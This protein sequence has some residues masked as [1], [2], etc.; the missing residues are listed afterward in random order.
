MADRKRNPWLVPIRKVLFR[1]AFAVFILFQFVVF[2]MLLWALSRILPEDNDFIT[3]T[4]IVL[5]LISPF[6]IGA[7]SY[8]VFQRMTRVEYILAESERWLAERRETRMAPHKWRRV[9]RHW[10]VWI[11]TLTVLLFCL[12]LDQTL[13]P[14]SHLLHPG[15][16]RLGAYR[17]SLPLDWTVVF[18]ESGP[19]GSPGRLYAVANRWTG[20]LGSAINE[21]HGRKPTMTSSALGCYSS[22]SE[23]DGS[24]SLGKDQDRPIRNRRYSME[25][26]TLTCEEVVSGNVQTDRESY[27]VSC[28]TAEHDF[29]CG[30]Y[31]G[32]KDESSEFYNMVERIKKTN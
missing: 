5:V 18:S 13:P 20:M 1:L 14:L 15:Y 22:P 25:N 27:I 32:N 30:L 12:F 19:E 6:A 10:M 11:P 31:G 21:F 3:G 17:V 8:V 26:M 7:T 16:G 24:F 2:V 29:Y 4:V 23:G 28:V 9:L